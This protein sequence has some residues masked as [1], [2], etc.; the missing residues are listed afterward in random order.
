MALLDRLFQYLVEKNRPL[1]PPPLPTRLGE[2][3]QPTIDAGNIPAC[4]MVEDTAADLSPTAGSLVKLLNCPTGYRV[5]VTD[6]LKG[7]S[8]GTSQWG[9]TLRGRS[10]VFP[11]TLASTSAIEN[12]S[13]NLVLLEGDQLGLITNGNVAD[14]SITMR[15]H[16]H[17]YIDERTIPYVV[18]TA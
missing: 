9:V 12:H 11:L 15:C 13:L 1:Q 4:K 7:A 3:L 17:F 5:V 10:G 6:L 2:T 14:T 16:G 8:V 18:V